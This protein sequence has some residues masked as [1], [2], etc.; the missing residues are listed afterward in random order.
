VRDDSFLGDV[1]FVG[2]TG[3]ISSA[4]TEVAVAKG[5]DVT[6]LV[7]GTRDHRLPED[8]EVLHGDV[9]E[10]APGV[11]E[12]LGDRHWDC[13]VDWICYDRDDVARDIE[14]FGDR[15]D[16][17]VLISSTAVYARPLPESPVSEEHDLGNPGWEYAEGKRRCEQAVSDYCRNEGLPGVI[18]RPGHTYAPF[19]LPTAIP[20]LGFEIIPWVEGGGPIPLHDRGLTKW[21]LTFNKD[22]ANA[23]IPLLSV[24]NIEG[25]AFHIASERSRTWRHVYDT[26]ADVF[27]LSPDYISLPSEEWG[28][29]V[30]EI[31]CSITHEKAYDTRF[32]LDKLRRHLPEYRTNVT[33]QDGLRRC[34]EWYQRH[35][36]EMSLS[37][38]AASRLRRLADHGAR[39]G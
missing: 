35:K 23:L 10:D 5:L 4:C 34:R 22:F 32:S 16:R 3:T 30:P 13:V 29:A 26:I 24:P 9:S 27:D 6:V 28:E 18:V 11:S 20:G 39:L 12:Q 33:L 37:P 8:V 31:G 21:A 14:L 19:V 15:T 17:Y 38:E 2:G 25:E 1:L 7:R 36:G